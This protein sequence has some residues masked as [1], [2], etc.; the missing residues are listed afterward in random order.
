MSLEKNNSEELDD[1]EEENLMITQYSDLAPVSNKD[2]VDQK[3]VRGSK[4]DGSMFD[5]RPAIER[6]INR[7]N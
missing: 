6:K 5:S 4:H 2:P 7:R 1:L 3:N